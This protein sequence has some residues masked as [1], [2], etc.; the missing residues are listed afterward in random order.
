MSDEMRCERVRELAPDVAIG[1]ADGQDRDAALRHA[2]TCADCRR[3]LGELSTV[4]DELLLLAPEHEPPPGFAVRTVD[5]LGRL[6]GSVAAGGVADGGRGTPRVHRSLR[7]GLR[8][9]PR[10]WMRRVAVGAAFVLAVALGAGTVFAATS[11]DRRLADSYRSVLALGRGSFFSASALRGPGGPVGTVWGY[12]GDPSWLFATAELPVASPTRFR[13]EVDTADG[14][15][16]ALGTD[17]LGPGRASWG[18]AIPVALT[19]VTSLRL[20]SLDGRTTFVAYIV[21]EDPWHA[22]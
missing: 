15:T 18:S 20:T 16:I 12:Q 21:A 11:G 8:G 2:A 13:V 6:S 17:T 3:L 1:I 5:R 14:R 22:G 4:V 9:A 7:P 10:P 19:D